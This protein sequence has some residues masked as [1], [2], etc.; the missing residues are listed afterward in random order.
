LIECGLHTDAAIFL[1]SGDRPSAEQMKAAVPAH[2][3]R[4]EWTHQN[5]AR[6]SLYLAELQEIIKRKGL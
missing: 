1:Y 2:L 4:Y 5:L 6:M 3:Q